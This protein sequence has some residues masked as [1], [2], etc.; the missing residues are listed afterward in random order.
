MTRG[1]DLATDGRVLPMSGPSSAPLRVLI[2]DDEPIA[3]QVL[4]DELETVPDIQVA[5]E[6]ENGE[7]ALAEIGRLH[8]D[9]VLLDLQMPGVG[10]FDVIRRIPEGSLPVVVIVTA[11]NEH[12]IRAFEAGAL[13]YLLKPV[14]R[15]RLEKTLDRVRALHHK[16]RDV[17]ESLVRLNEIEE[18]LAAQRS[19]KIVGRTGEEYYL[20]DLDDVLA[21]QAEREIVWIVTARRR[22]TATHN[23]RSIGERLRDSTFQR[24]HRNAL[25]NVNH[26]RKMAPLSSQ[27]WLLT[28]TNGQEFIVSKRQAREVRQLLQW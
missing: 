13:D 16:K 4:R 10:G 17:A 1:P 25:V 6:A 24:V 28:L 14:S 3:R 26:V 18:G 21:F 2:V 9:L 12:A 23:L 27:R 8:P 20:L 7:R 22:Y 19:R 11:Y 15:E 5:G